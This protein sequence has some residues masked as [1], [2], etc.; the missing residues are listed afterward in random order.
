MI[1]LRLFFEFFK[2]KFLCVFII[3]PHI[4]SIINVFNQKFC[5]NKICIAMLVVCEIYLLG[6]EV[7]QY[8][9]SNSANRI[10][11]IARNSIKSIFSL[12]I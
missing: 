9:I 6:H 10:Y 5:G 2:R 12:Q 4:K 3:S 11:Y 1:Y 8:R 7:Q